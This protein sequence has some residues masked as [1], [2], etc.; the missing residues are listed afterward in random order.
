VF[1]VGDS[2]RVHIPDE[3]R[4]FKVTLPGVLQVA[5]FMVPIDG[6]VA[7]VGAVLITTFADGPE[8]QLPAETVN[9]YVPVANP[10]IVLVAP[11]PVIVPPGVCVI[12]HVPAGSPVR[13]TLPVDKAQ[14]GCV[15]VPTTGGAI[16]LTDM[17]S[18]VALLVPQV[19][20][21]ATDRFPDVAPAVKVIV[22]ELVVPPAIVPPV[23]A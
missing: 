10:E 7:G 17:K 1:P 6:A 8:V 23:P 20:V 18:G 21:P 14:V 15:I 22:I 13:S 5:L 19:V 3:G 9:V 4:L 11:V 12:V 2:V 16:V